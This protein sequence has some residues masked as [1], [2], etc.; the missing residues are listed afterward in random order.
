M[1]FNT[2]IQASTNILVIVNGAPARWGIKKRKQ[3]KDWTS[4]GV[5]GKPS[6]LQR[7]LRIFC[8]EGAVRS[9]ARGR[10][11]AKQKHFDCGE[12]D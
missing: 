11:P 4:L 2:F 8:G 6:L 9:V 3:K 7:K 5:A 10:R 1:W 12:G